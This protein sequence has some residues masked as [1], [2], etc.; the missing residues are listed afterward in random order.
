[1][2]TILNSLLAAILLAAAPLAASAPAAAQPVTIMAYG[3][4]LVHGYGLPPGEAFPTQLE[5]ALSGEGFEVEVINAGN[6]GETSKGGRERLAWTLAEEPD[7]LVL[8]LGANDML[9]GL[10]PVKTEENLA[11]ILEELQRRDI[12]VLLAGMKAHRGLGG[13]YVRVFDGVYPELAE[14]YRVAFYPF[15]LEGVAADPAL[16]QSDGLHPNARGVDKIVRQMLP[17]LI[18]LIEE[19]RTAAAG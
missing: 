17:Y 9:R 5:A 10:D 19:E 2:K 12:R 8:V 7:I 15:F 13:D 11:A 4:S 6:S 1:M 3:D 18:P 16:N 14:R